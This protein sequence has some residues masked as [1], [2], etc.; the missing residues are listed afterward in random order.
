MLRIL[1]AEGYHITFAPYAWRDPKYTVF[2]RLRGV[3][4]IPPSKPEKWAE[5]HNFLLEGECIYAAILVA[6]RAIY[7]RAREILAARCPGVPIIYDTV[8]LHFLREARDVISAVNSNGAKNVS[9]APGSPRARGTEL[10]ALEVQAAS[11]QVCS[12]RVQGQS[13]SARADSS[14]LVHAGPGGLGL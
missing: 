13:C 14:A 5:K 11:W 9:G 8:D 7:L 6:R 3:H 10:T 12:F 4:I 2:A 1:L